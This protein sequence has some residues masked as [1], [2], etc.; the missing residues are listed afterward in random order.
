MGA[1]DPHRPPEQAVI[2]DCV[3]CGFCLET[4]PTYVLWGAE[5]DSPRGRIVLVN[6][7]LNAVES[8]SDE[9]VTHFDRCLGC[10]ACVTACPSG[11]RY[12]RLIERVRP[13]VERHHRR[14]PGERAIRRLLYETLPHPKRLRALAP[15]LTASRRL[16]VERRL[17]ERLAA[18]AKVAPQAPSGRAAKAG[19]PERT[20][21][22]GEPRGRVGLLL[23]CV[24]RIFY[25]GVHRATVHALA[26]E[27]FEVLAPAEPDCCGAL[28][29]H[30]G[31][32]PAA[33]RRALETIRAFA[34]VDHIVVNAAGCG[35]A[36]KEYGELLG[37]PEARDFSARVRDVSELLASV[38]PRA[39]RGPV[40]LRVAYHD[41][42]HLAHA[43]GVRSAPR[44]LLRAI[45]GLE[46]VEVGAERDVCC[47]SAGIYN[48]VQPEAAAALGARKARHLIDTGAQAIAAGN[49]GCA[50]QLDL[51][52]RQLGTPLPIHHPVELISRSIAAARAGGR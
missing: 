3:H 28:E 2:D 31:E 17:P 40:P 7:G 9:M 44:E 14:T 33:V 27:G 43:Q 4:C 16:G 37:T 19:V 36:M 49:P 32:E 5:A 22:V 23:G 50:A 18:I 13:Q 1:F 47:G 11:V 15:M 38:P 51:H 39:P 46:L 30:G 48:L 25:P 8:L 12:D 34:D 29:F 24:Q 6:D 45:P 20:P 35:S 10:M 52:L 42:C 26:A 41:A 21:A